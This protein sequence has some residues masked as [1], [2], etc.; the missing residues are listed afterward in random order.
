MKR[1]LIVLLLVAALLLLVAAP[2]LA[3]VHVRIPG[4]DCGGGAEN[5][6]ATAAITSQDR[7]G[8]MPPLGDDGG[9]DQAPDDFCP[10]DA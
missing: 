10:R 8:N 9:H 6:T 2:A 3:F 5:P 7:R 1:A 4:D